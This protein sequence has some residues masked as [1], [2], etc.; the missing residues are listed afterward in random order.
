MLSPSW[1][2]CRDIADNLELEKGVNKYLAGRYQP[3]HST[4]GQ[5]HEDGQIGPTGITMLMMPVITL[6]TDIQHALILHMA[7]AA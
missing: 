1:Q 2:T 5:E 6:P 3:T 4:L 7:S